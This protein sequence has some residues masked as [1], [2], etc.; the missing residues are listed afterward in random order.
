MVKPLKK[1]QGAKA[2]A[3]SNNANKGGKSNNNSSKKSSRSNKKKL[4]D[5]YQYDNINDKKGNK[6]GREGLRAGLGELSDNSDESEEEKGS[7]F[8]RKVGRGGESENDDD[9]SVDDEGSDIGWDSDDDFGDFYNKKN[10]RKGAFK[11]DQLLE[12]DNDSGSDQEVPNDGEILLS[13]LLGGSMNDAVSKSQAYKDAMRGAVDYSEEESEEEEDDED[14]ST[15]NASS[16][17]NSG[18]NSGDD[19]DDDSDDDNNNSDDDESEDDA[20]LEKVHTRLLSAIDKFAQTPETTQAEIAS[21]KISNQQHAP[22]SVFSS[23]ADQ[24]IAGGGST[25]SMDALLGAL[26]DGSSTV[27]T[28][29]LSAVKKTLTE[30][31]QGLS[32]AVPSYV[33]KVTTKRIER[34]LAYDE[35][36][37]DMGKWQE[38]VVANR[39]LKTL[40]LAQD[41]RQLPSYKN[42]VKKFQPEND[43]EKEISMVLVKS[44]ATEKA[45]EDKEGDDLGFRQIT[46]KEIRERQAELAKVKAL[47]F[48]DQMKRHRLNKIK[49]KAYHRIQK[50]KRI[51]KDGDEKALLA[52]IDPLAAK[53]L[54]EEEA[55]KR[56]KERMDLKH[57]NTGKWAKMAIQHGHSDKS[58]R[59]AYHESVQLGKEISKRIN[60][61]NVDKNDEDRN[62]DDDSD[63]D[64]DR[65]LS[66]KKKSTS[67]SAAR[68]MES[69]LGG[70]EDAPEVEGKYKK[71]FD[72]DFMKKASEQRQEK[73]REEAQ[74]VLR[75]IEN[76]EGD[77]SDDDDDDDDENK[78]L[79]KQ[80]RKANEEAI[81][82]EKLN[83][84]RGEVSSMLGSNG[85]SITRGKGK[86]KMDG[87]IAVNNA[88]NVNNNNN[89]NTDFDYSWNDDDDDN[90]NSNN[91]NKNDI[92][93][94][95]PF[96]APLHHGKSRAGKNKKGDTKVFVKGF[97]GT[98]VD[99]DN[100]QEHFSSYRNKKALAAGGVNN[101]KVSNNKVSNNNSE[102]VTSTETK[103][104]TVVKPAHNER[105]PLLMQ[106]SQSDLVQLAFAGPDLEE[107]FRSFK[108]S[109]IDRELGI[110]EQRKKIISSVKA[111][112]G[113][114]SG[115]GSTG[116]SDKII[117]KRDRLMRKVDEEADKKR[118]N[119]N[120]KK[121]M[122]VMISDKRVKTAAKFKISE[123]PH[124]FTSREEYER[125]LQMPLGGEW[126]A[127]HVVKKVTKPEILL[128]AGRII[129]PIKLPKKRQSENSKKDNSTKKYIK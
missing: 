108:E 84:A 119:R 66:S 27:T 117:K 60:N 13:D 44:G 62:S 61:D 101:N 47:M 29:N 1:K 2:N 128:R 102:S 80:K 79:E 3:K 19:S 96:L 64:S 91:R 38:T 15:L 33:D 105:K 110:E 81:Y 55:T 31:E 120:D 67:R 32:K 34:T 6:F 50:R 10:G 89:N 75:E 77:V 14:Y 113:D 121:M 63:F 24:S 45:A 82:K 56:V 122:N 97:E 46:T 18:D 88:A 16:G 49:S 87:P 52:E 72:M 25:V 70:S 118:A 43:F 9:E 11:K 124:P 71:L 109:S 74:A 4:V 23:V 95:N 106:K 59:E 73:A 127:L 40:D 94:V 42:L 111:G 116:V 85:M 58:L 69:V 22:E 53:E 112:W 100:K 30:L 92:D 54:E 37:K 126:N 78:S 48:Y 99:E 125:S 76:M 103:S 86:V 98:E 8:T 41:K 20:E 57:A 114:W 5:V 107:D 68:A 36:S 51:K 35:T 28:A 39:H 123:I 12:E 7:K 129:E 90:N 104:A 65:D 83:I 21:S 17:D 26:G 115:P 93:E